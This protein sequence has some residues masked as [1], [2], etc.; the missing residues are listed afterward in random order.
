MD[1]SQNNPKRIMTDATN[2]PKAP[3][4]P[5][6]DSLFLP[7]TAHVLRVRIADKINKNCF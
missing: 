6:V 5:Y 4:S 3:K 7:Q 1:V 2:N